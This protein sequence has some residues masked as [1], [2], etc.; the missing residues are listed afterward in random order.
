MNFRNFRHT[1]FIELKNMIHAL[2]SEDPG[3]EPITDTKISKTVRKLCENPSKGRIII[4]EKGRV[5]IGYA[6]LIFYWSDEYGGDILH[7]D[8]LYVKPAHRGRGVATR[9]FKHIPR[10]FKDIV[11]FQLEVNSSNS[12]AKNYYRKLGFKKTRNTHMIRKS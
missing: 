5:T 3:N 9:F 11:A 8:E 2:Y 4:F 10:T 6:I 12:K 7:I 1:D